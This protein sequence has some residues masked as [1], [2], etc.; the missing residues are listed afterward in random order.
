MLK[1]RIWGFRRFLRNE[2]SSPW[3]KVMNSQSWPV[4]AH[5]AKC[6]GNPIVKKMAQKNVYNIY[7]EPP[8]AS[9]FPKIGWNLAHIGLHGTDRGIF[10]I[11]CFW[12]FTGPGRAKFGQILK[13]RPNLALPRAVKIRK[14][15]ISKIP[16]SAVCNFM[17]ARSQPIFGQIEAPGGSKIC[18]CTSIWT[19]HA[20]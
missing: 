11:L 4:F 3:C 18:N 14:H 8:G 15:K 9:I 6:I 1:F 20:G 13:N 2:K 17:W 16:Q 19:Y 10:D 12:I 5:F 7:F